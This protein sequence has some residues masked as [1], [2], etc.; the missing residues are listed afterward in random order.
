MILFVEPVNE[1]PRSLQR[2]LSDLFGKNTMIQRVY[3]FQFASTIG[4]FEQYVSVHWLQSSHAP[5]RVCTSLKSVHAGPPNAL[6]GIPVPCMR[7]SA[8]I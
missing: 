1:Q 7:N 8:D 2:V 6:N 4:Y 3:L 5:G